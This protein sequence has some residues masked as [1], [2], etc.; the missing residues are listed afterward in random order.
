MIQRRLDGS[1]D[2]DQLWE[3]Y[4][5]GFGSLN[6]KTGSERDPS[7]HL[8]ADF[9]ISLPSPP[10]VNPGWAWRRSTPSLKTEATS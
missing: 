8:G 5:R 2:F 4:L 3:A 10:Q 1:V 9:L 6:G 7:E